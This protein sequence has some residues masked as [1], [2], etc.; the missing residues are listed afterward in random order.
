[1]CTKSRQYK[2]VSVM[3]ENCV[4][5]GDSALYASCCACIS[6]EVAGPQFPSPP[7]YYCMYTAIST[8]QL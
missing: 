2:Y 1:M 3:T 7:K 4:W 6:N 8:K 5:Q